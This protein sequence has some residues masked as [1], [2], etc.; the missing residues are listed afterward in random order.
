MDE[1]NESKFVDGLAARRALLIK[2]MDLIADPAMKDYAAA[3]IADSEGLCDSLRESLAK[4]GEAKAE[5]AVEYA[6]SLEKLDQ[7]LKECAE[8]EKAIAARNLAAKSSPSI[9]APPNLDVRLR[10]EVNRFFKLRQAFSDSKSADSSKSLQSWVF[11]E[12]EISE[13]PPSP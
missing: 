11:D 5:L 4:A 8:L 1:I 9:S 6:A 10:S 13:F 12:S 7:K 3:L 2:S